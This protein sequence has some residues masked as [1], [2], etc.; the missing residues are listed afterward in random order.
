MQ[1]LV[2]LVLG[3]CAGFVGAWLYE[4]TGSAAP[5]GLTILSTPEQDSLNLPFAEGVRIGDIIYLSGQI[6]AKPGTMELVP[7]GI[8]A[9]TRQPLTNIEASLARYGSSM[10]QVFKCTVF[11]K[12]MADWPAMNEVYVEMF[13]GHRPARSALGASGLAL[14]GNVEIECF[15]HVED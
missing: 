4:T 9:E 14:D 6:G 11:M 10:D 3:L 12:D 7:G 13:D 8:Q 15:A 1:Y 5:A 2:T